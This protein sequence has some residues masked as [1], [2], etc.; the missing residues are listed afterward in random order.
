VSTPERVWDAELVHPADRLPHTG[1]GNQPRDAILVDPEGPPAAGL[2]SRDQ[3]RDALVLDAV[4][5]PGSGGAV[6]LAEMVHRASRRWPVRLLAWLVGLQ[7]KLA[8]LATI[9]AGLAV[10]ATFPLA[11]FVSLGY[12]LE[13]SGRVAR[14]GRP[15][16][17]F[18]GLHKAAGLGI[19][20][21]GAWV[22]LLP[23]RFVS[24]MAARARLIEPGGLADRGWSLGLWFMVLLTIAALAL[25]LIGV[26]MCGRAVESLVSGQP[27]AAAWRLPPRRRAWEPRLYVWVRDRLWEFAV[28]L[29]VPYY[30]W[31]GLRGFAG[32]MIWLVLPIS[33]LALGSSGHPVA[34]F[35]GALGLMLVLLYLPFLQTRFAAEN[36]FAA[37]FEVGAVRR[38][39]RKAPVGFW[40]AVLVTLAFAVP[41]YLLKIEIVP[42][43]AAWLPSLVFVIF[44]LPA[45][46]LVG[47]VCGYAAR[48]QRPR[49]WFVRQAA[50]LAML[51]VVGMYVLIV[52]F[53]QYTSWYGVASL[54]EQHAFL[55][56]VPFLGL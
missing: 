45:R 39:F 32:G 7:V 34:G 18:V 17:G 15:R 28:G 54:Y 43:E 52:Y 25:W 31:L 40:L 47:W 22:L 21:A 19:F 48:R 37:M 50:R 14:S 9:V 16:D 10:L 38:L 33:L 3:P 6:V 13:C 49:N 55:V 56:P 8:G 30:F 27:M 35:L 4:G 12:L 46:L 41:L 20:V 51:P 53:T 11:Q 5:P 26:L 36:R 29:R 2:A 42:R 1:D 24:S 23:V 44:I